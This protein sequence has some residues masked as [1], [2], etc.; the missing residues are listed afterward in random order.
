MAEDTAKV[1]PVA[2]VS[3]TAAR[4]EGRAKQGLARD[5]AAAV[6]KLRNDD[7]AQ[8]SRQSVG[9]AA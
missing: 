2:A 1:K 9:K 5:L 8:I 4:L 3:S 6:A 7:G